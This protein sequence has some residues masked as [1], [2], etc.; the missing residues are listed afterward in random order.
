[1][2][3]SREKLLTT[4]SNIFF[5][6]PLIIAYK[7]KNIPLVLLLI[8]IIIFSTVYHLSKRPGM[9]WYWYKGRTL[10]HTLFLYLDSLLALS[11]FVYVLIETLSKPFI[12]TTWLGI[13]IFIIGFTSFIFPNKKD[14]G[15]LH[16]IWHLCAGI[17]FAL[18]LL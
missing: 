14:Y 3:L 9:D 18:V 10:I 13:S 4:A 16:A 11:I 5:I 8:G 15:L 17:A 6:L 7:S 2:K 12:F 1:M